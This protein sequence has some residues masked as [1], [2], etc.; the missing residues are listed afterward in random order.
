MDTAVRNASIGI[1]PFGSEASASRTGPGIARDS[2]ICCSRSLNWT[3]VGSLSSHNKYATS[4]KLVSA[5]K[6]PISIPR[7]VRRPT[8]PSTELSS[9][10]PAT[11]PR[12]PLSFSAIY[13]SQRICA[14]CNTFNVLV[15]QRTGP[16]YHH[17]CNALSITHCMRLL[18][19]PITLI[20]SVLI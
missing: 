1:V 6:S 17:Q 7:Y 15:P 12:R 3:L 11:T 19:E 14:S 20:L 2:L 5:A 18:T 16:T 8:S 10:R 13:L 4:S 9:E